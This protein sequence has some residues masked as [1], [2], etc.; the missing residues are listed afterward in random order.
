MSSRLPLTVGLCGVLSTLAFAQQP[1]AGQVSFEPYTLTTYDGQ[2]HPAELGHLWVRENRENNSDRLIRLTF[3]RLKSSAAN[4]GSPIVYLA[5]G[6]GIPGIVMA[7]VPVYYNLF[8]K[9][10]QVGD[11]I[12]L[13]QRGL[14]MSS[15]NLN[16]CP[17][18][19]KFPKKSKGRKISFPPLLNGR[20]KTDYEPATC[21]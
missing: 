5:G 12:L 8:E 1:H 15:P 4:P 16:D 21:S 18:G 11:V 10:H 9:L 14:G 3:V 19:G 13:D 6:P 7:R 2:S 17:T 20:R